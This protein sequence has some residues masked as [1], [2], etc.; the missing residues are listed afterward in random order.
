LKIYSRLVIDI[1]TGLVTEADSYEYSGPVALCKGATSEQKNLEA[2]QAAFYSVMTADYK[3]QFARQSAI[4]QALDESWSPVLAGGINQYGFSAAEDTALRSAATDQTAAE[5][6]KAAKATNEN[7]AAMGGGNEFLPSGAADQL[8]Q[9]VATESAAQSAA[10]NLAITEAGYN[11]GR[12]D[13]LAASSALG[14]FADTYN[15]TSYASSANTAGS[16]AASTASA[17]Q[18]ADAAA[19]PWSTIGGIVGG[20]ASSFLGGPGFASLVGGAGK[21]AG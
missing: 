3:Q 20:A 4:L 1:A 8:K 14:G 6:Q 2:Q 19:S 18:Q 12:A 16:D 17:I 15:P 13:Y 7:I 21:S 5:Y 10:Q 11:Q 9:E